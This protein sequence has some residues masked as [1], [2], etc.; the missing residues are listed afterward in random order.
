MLLRDIVKVLDG[1]ILCGSEL[2]DL[3]IQAGCG[4]DLMSDVMAFV[5]DQVILLTGLVNV[6]VIR[7]AEM[8]DIKVVCFVR[9]KQPTQQVLDLAKAKGIAIITTN[10]PLF[11]ASGMLYEAGLKERGVWN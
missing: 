8:M 10:N 7:T 3:D 9:G 1:E 2:L 6:Q 5:K 11:I 4:A